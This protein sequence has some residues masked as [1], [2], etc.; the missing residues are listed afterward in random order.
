MR[1][2]LYRGIPFK[3]EVYQ[4]RRDTTIMAFIPLTNKTKAVVITENMR[5]AIRMAREEIDEILDNK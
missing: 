5:E 2:M 4:S 1:G 3:I